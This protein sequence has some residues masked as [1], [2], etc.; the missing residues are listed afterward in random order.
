MKSN[1]V[2]SLISPFHYPPLYSLFKY[3]LV[4]LR[5]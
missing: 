5:L 3:M 1:V 2:S 4:D